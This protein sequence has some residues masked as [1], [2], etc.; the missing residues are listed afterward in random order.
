MNKFQPK[1]QGFTLIE[2][3]LVVVLV[4]IIGSASAP[5]YQSFQVKNNLSVSANIIIQALRRAQVLS[6]SGEGD[7]VWGVHIANG[8]AILFKGA[9]FSGRDVAFDE[10]SEISSNITPTGIS[11]VVYSKLLGVPQATG[12]IILTTLNNDAKTITLNEKGTLEY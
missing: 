10:V 7:S 9:S 6:Q 1:R 2:I 11:D 5:V 12:S 3:M 8:G 4:V